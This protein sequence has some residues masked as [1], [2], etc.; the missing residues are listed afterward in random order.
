MINSVIPEYDILV[1]EWPQSNYIS[2]NLNPQDSLGVSVIY[3]GGG[4][5]T[6]YP[7]VS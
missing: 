6:C 7:I 5:G 3:Y 4:G 1:S 2:R